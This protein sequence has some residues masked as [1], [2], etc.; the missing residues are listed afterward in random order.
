MLDPQ[1]TLGLPPHS[2][3][4]VRNGCARP[5]HRIFH[6]HQG[7][8]LYGHAESPGDSHDCRESPQSVCQRRRSSG[9]PEHALCELHGR[10][11]VFQYPERT[12]ITPLHWP[13]VARFHLPHGLLTAF[14]CP[15]V[16]EYNLLAAPEKFKEIARAF[17]ENPD[18]LPDIEG[19]RLAVKAVKGLLDDLGISYKLSDYNVP[20]E[21]IPALSQGH[22]GSRA[23]HQ[24]Q[25]QKTEPGG[26]REGSARELLARS[27]YGNGRLL[28]LIAP[29][30]A[31]AR[32]TTGNSELRRT[33]KSFCILNSFK[34]TRPTIDVER[35]ALFTESMRQTE[36]EHLTLAGPKRSSTLRKY[37]SLY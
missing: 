11:G 2:H 27:A 7:D 9:A 36:G 20:I 19:A 14:I 32:R 22:D 1:L 29:R 15:W 6:R 35:A 16:M 10:H 31:S 12:W 17:G 5:R 30:A 25:S 28:H 26:S 4:Q 34:G 33:R 23:A 21:A 24:Q 3:R 37:L 18:G 8:G 13:S